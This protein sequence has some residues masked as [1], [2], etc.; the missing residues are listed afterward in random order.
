M[1]SRAL[2]RE[3]GE[4]EIPLLV[5]LGAGASSDVVP[6]TVELTRP[7]L[8][9]WVPI[10]DD[11]RH[12]RHNQ[13]HCRI[14][15]N[16]ATTHPEAG[17]NFEHLLGLA[18]EEADRST[19]PD[20]QSQWL[21]GVMQG[22]HEVAINI[23]TALEGHRGASA[24]TRLLERLARTFPLSLASLNW[25]DLPLRAS[26]ISWH[27]GF[28]HDVQSSFDPDLLRTSNG[29]RLYWLHGSLHF[30]RNPPD[31]SYRRDTSGQRSASEFMV[32]YPNAW[33]AL[34]WWRV[35]GIPGEPRTILRFPIVTAA[36]KVN[37][38]FA[39]PFLDYWNQFLED[40]RHVPAICVIGYSGGD[41][42]CNMVLREAIRSNRRLHTVV[43]VDKPSAKNLDELYGTMFGK[44]RGIFQLGSDWKTPPVASPP[45][46]GFHRLAWDKQTQ[47][48]LYPFG[49]ECLA[50]TPAHLERLVGLLRCYEQPTSNAMRW[51]RQSV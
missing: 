13:G 28:H 16:L 27:D 20:D 8:R 21:T 15:K 32:W 14:F 33:E 31:P 19:N 25:D 22:A 45:Q 12:P 26:A 18:F 44:L 39:P 1:D 50:N 2:S 41:D 48:W 29:H 40:A 23:Q 47:L 10:S 5:L 46:H 36:M 34:H 38:L 9:R 30:T 51:F 42:H 17:Q 35:M 4:M 49:I 24:S 11:P 7:L 43:W 3:N 6:G 37:Q